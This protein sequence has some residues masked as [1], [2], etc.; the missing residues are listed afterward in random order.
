MPTPRLRPPA[1]SVKLG[2]WTARVSAEVALMDPDVPV[3]V[4]LYWPSV[5]APLA[6]RVSVV[7][8]VA[9]FGLKE[10]VTPVGKP[11]IEKFTLPANPYCG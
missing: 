10:A 8:E 5:A 9:G 6:V 4:R 2:V 7:E 3:M 1:D 11:E